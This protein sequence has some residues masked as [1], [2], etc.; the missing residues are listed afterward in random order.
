MF[1]SS[2]VQ[3]L[4]VKF[5]YIEVMLSRV[6][7]ENLVFSEIQQFFRFKSKIPK[8]LKTF[9]QYCNLVSS[10][11][12]FFFNSEVIWRRVMF[13]NFLKFSVFLVY[14]R[15]KSKIPKLPKIVFCIQVQYPHLTFSYNAVIWSRN[16]IKNLNFSKFTDFF[17][18]S[19]PK[20][21]ISKHS[22]IV[23]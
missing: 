9:F 19:A 10:C 21:K 12:D 5:C 17:P 11:K 14:H 23:F 1:F 3:S 22:K 4:H 20:W 6:T 16:V 2:Q 13:W 18:F 8:S 15:L 7:F